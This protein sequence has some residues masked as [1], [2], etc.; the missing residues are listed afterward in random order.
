MV[1]ITQKS[2]LKYNHI[3]IMLVMIRDKVIKYMC[4]I[5]VFFT[6]KVKNDISFL[7]MTEKYLIN[8]KII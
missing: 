7:L 1:S 8:L 4:V 3:I 2:L 6:R 5:R